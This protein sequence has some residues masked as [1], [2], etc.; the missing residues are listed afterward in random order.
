MVDANLDVVVLEELPEG[1]RRVEVEV[2]RREQAAADASLLELG[3]NVHEGLKPAL[4]HK[5]N[6]EIE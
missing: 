1:G 4:A 6:T 2:R 5:R 3:E